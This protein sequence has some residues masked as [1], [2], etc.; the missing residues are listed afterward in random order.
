MVA[1]GWFF[2]SLR[3]SAE[4]LTCAVPLI[5]RPVHPHSSSGN[6]N[7]IFT[8]ATSSW[9]C[10]LL[11]RATVSRSHPCLVHLC[12]HSCRYSLFTQN[13]WRFSSPLPLPPLLCWPWVLVILHFPLVPVTS[14]FR[15]SP[16]PSHLYSVSLWLA[17]IP[18]HL[19]RFSSCCSLLPLQITVFF[20]RQSL[21]R[22]L[23]KRIRD[24]PWCSSIPPPSPPLAHPSLALQTS[25][26]CPTVPVQNFPKINKNAAK[27]FVSFAVTLHP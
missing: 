24:H 19:F 8:S 17:S 3:L 21:C 22:F 16:S 9:A 18:L 11:L 20:K 12:L 4:P 7:V 25:S 10:C 15:L 13:S 27:L 26:Y 2:H 6:L 5:L 14:P 1:Q 23:S